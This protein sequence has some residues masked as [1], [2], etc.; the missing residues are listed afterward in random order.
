MKPGMLPG[1]FPLFAKIKSAR[2]RPGE[3]GGI[4]PNAVQTKLAGRRRLFVLSRFSRRGPGPDDRRAGNAAVA[5]SAGRSPR[6]RVG[7]WIDQIKFVNQKAE[8]FGVVGTLRLEWQDPA[9]A[10]DAAEYGRDFRFFEPE[11]FETFASE[12]ALFYPGFVIQNQQERRFR[13]SA[14]FIVS[15]TGQ[16]YYVESFTTVLQAPHFNFVSFPFDT[17]EFFVHVVS[18]YP[19]SHV[20]YVPLTSHSGI[21]KK[22]GE[23][24][25]TFTE[26]WTKISTHE[27]ITGLPSSRFTL[28][29]RAQRHLDYYVIRI[30][31]PLAIFVA[32]SWAAFFLQEY[33][34]RIDIAGANLLIFVAFN[35]AISGDLPRLGY[36]T[37]LDFI[38]V[39]MF[40]INGVIIV[41]NV[42]L[43]RLR[44]NDR[45]DRS[46]SLRFEHYRSAPANQQR[47]QYQARLRAGKCSRTCGRP[48]GGARSVISIG[49]P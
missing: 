28:G 14:R 20:K 42:G 18:T 41:F 49:L 25:W 17:Q 39:A 26:N 40:V 30:F 15:S 33:R 32:V 16:A 11:D 45:D 19:T 3:T 12:N 47:A 38:L 6:G 36:M 4:A 44:V 10:F 13:Q 48:S 8:N 5:A 22:L 34:R 1:G 27:G 29:L 24:E 35:F 7:V 37:F 23:E 9:L 2:M 43:R 46:R 31:T 21:G